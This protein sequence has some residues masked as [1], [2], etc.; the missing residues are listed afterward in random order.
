MY[1]K[2]C[3]LLALYKDVLLVFYFYFFLAPAKKSDNEN[4]GKE[5]TYNETFL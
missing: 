4:T 5:N 2:N 3:K 1:F